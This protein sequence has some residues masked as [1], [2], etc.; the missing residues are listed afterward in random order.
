MINIF[1]S[2]IGSW[3]RELALLFVIISLIDIIMPKGK[4][5][6]YV[7]LIIG[8]III[9]AVISPLTNLNNIYFDLDQEVSNF[10]KEEITVDN[11]EEIRNE[12]I[13]D[14][15]LSRLNKEL[16]DIIEENSAYSVS[17]ISFRTTP[18]DENM[19]IIQGVD[20]LLSKEKVKSNILVEK[21]ELGKDS[22]IVVSKVDDDLLNLISN[23][24]QMDTEK[25]NITVKEEGEDYGKTN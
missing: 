16:K 18:D 1:Q 24:I 9:F 6:R 19:F 17:N 21:I 22:N 4:M 10:T 7:D 14:L 11:I 5:K 15:Y 13:K 2:F 20:I 8:I 23:I 3:L 12:Q 25:I